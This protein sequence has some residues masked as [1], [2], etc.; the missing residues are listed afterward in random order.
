MRTEEAQTLVFEVKEAMD[1]LIEK[2]R[3]DGVTLPG[4]IKPLHLEVVGNK[5][6]VRL[7]CHV[8]TPPAAGEA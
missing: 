4:V 3:K 6:E 7:T 2:A 8:R 5:G 1:A